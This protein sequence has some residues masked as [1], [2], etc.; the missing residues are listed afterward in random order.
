MRELQ[1]TLIILAIL[2]VS[3]TFA[4]TVTT[5]QGQ[6]IGIMAVILTL[7]ALMAQAA[8]HQ[9][10]RTALAREQMQQHANLAQQQRELIASLYEDDEEPE[11]QP[12]TPTLAP[13]QYAR[14]RAARR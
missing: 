13:T 12:A 10:E 1:W 4:P 7:W 14:G 8:H 2:M 11:A 9:R 3:V 5:T 6:F